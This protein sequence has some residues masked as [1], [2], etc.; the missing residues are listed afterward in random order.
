[1]RPRVQRDDAVLLRSVDYGESDRVL[2]FLTRG[3]GKFSALAKGA[4]RSRRRFAGALEPFA[5]LKIETV[6]ARS[7]LARLE[8][9]V[10]ERAFPKLLGDLPRMTVAGGLLAFVRELVPEAMPDPEVFDDVVQLLTVLDVGE[11]SERALRICFELA[12]MSRAGFSP[13]LEACGVCGKR[14]DAG[15]ATDFDARRGFVVCQSCGGASFR[16]RAGARGAWREACAGD[17]R[18]A[19]SAEWAAEDLEVS[20]RAVDSFI[21]H[22]LERRRGTG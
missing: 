1:M 12:Q 13:R 11:V 19:A 14:P 20:S 8:T 22:R 10:I 16:L 7:G 4:R 2:T 3:Q 15:R 5:L 18:A 17:F 9:A 6:A 21:E